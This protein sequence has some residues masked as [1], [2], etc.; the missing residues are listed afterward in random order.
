MKSQ[1]AELAAFAK[2]F[3]GITLVLS[4]LRSPEDASVDGLHYGHLVFHGWIPLEA[5]RIDALREQAFPGIGNIEPLYRVRFSDS[6]LAMARQIAL[7]PP[8]ARGG[9]LLRL[10]TDNPAL[11]QDEETALCAYIAEA[12]VA[13][14]LYPDL[15][16]TLD[17][18]IDFDRGYFLRKGLYDRSFN[19]RAVASMLRHL[20]VLLADCAGR[21]RHA[22]RRSENGMD[23]IEISNTEETITLLIGTGRRKRAAEA[24][25]GIMQGAEARCCWDLLKGRR[26]APDGLAASEDGPFAYFLHSERRDTSPATGIAETESTSERAS[27]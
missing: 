11:P 20:S 23:L 6:P 24:H 19:P 13:A 4:K 5:P 18:M 17:A 16:I 12:T 22:R 21:F 3:P 10:A 7:L 27:S 26:V 1:A 9:M 15:R 25:S 8:T 14:F 2:E